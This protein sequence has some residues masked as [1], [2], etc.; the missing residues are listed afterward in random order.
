M[1]LFKNDVS[2]FVGPAHGAPIRLVVTFRPVS[3]SSDRFDVEARLSGVEG[4]TRGQFVARS[5][6]NY[7]TSPMAASTSMV[8]EQARAKV[9]TQLFSELFSGGLSRSWAQAIDRRRK[10]GLLIV[11]RSSS[12]AVQGLPWELLSDP[13]ATSTSYVSFDAGMSII[14]QLLPADPELAAELEKPLEPV[15]QQRVRLLAITTRIPG[16]D[17]GADPAIMREA[18]PEAR[19]HHIPD[20][21]PKEILE[22]LERDEAHV[23]HL[24]GTGRPTRSGLQDMVAGTGGPADTV[25]AKS[26]ARSLHTSEQLR[27]LVLAACNTDQLASQLATRTRAVVGIRGKISDDGVRAFLRGL[28]FALASGATIPQAVASGRAQ[29]ISFSPSA[30]DEWSQAVLFLNADG[31]IVEASTRE[32]EPVAAAAVPNA[33]SGLPEE[34]TATNL[35]LVIKQA[36]LAALRE[37]WDAV[38]GSDTPAFVQ[39]Q[40][41]AL[42]RDIGPKRHAGSA[43]RAGTT[44]RGTAGRGATGGA[45]T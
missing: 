19:L 36:N 33:G 28:Y 37:Q 5:E 26:L 20:A 32:P 30:G 44:G 4:V 17:Q 38:E 16:L 3:G 14:R 42:A 41:D 18:F 2:E 40:I 43:A 23:V 12:P 13:S 10:R 39:D 25:P 15:P 21:S 31:P 45:A 11:I 6:W 7:A 8:S 24:M 35:M 1:V 29:Q 34:T 22:S 27:L 9:G